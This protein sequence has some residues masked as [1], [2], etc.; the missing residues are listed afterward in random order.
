MNNGKRKFVL[1]VAAAATALALGASASYAER[2]PQMRKALEKLKD[3]EAHLQL[4][5][6][7]KGGHRVRAMRLVRDAIREVQAG[8]RFDNRN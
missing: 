3:A 2:Q 7:D 5:T 8:I 6:A 4:A 1:V